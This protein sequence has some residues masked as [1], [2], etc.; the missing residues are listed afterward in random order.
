MP[1]LQHGIRAIGTLAQKKIADELNLAPSTVSRALA[2]KYIHTP[3]GT[4]PVEDFFFAE[5][6]S[7]RVYVNYLIGRV[8]DESWENILLGHQKMADRIRENFGIKVSRRF[9]ASIRRISR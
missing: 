8:V 2:D 7:S 5:L 9:I 4:F 1:F 6:S 3:H